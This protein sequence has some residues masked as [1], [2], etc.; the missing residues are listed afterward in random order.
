M[1]SKSRFL[2]RME[3]LSRSGGQRWRS[4]DGD[5]YYEW[6]P[7]HREIEVYDRRGYHLGA[8]DPDTG[9]VFKPAKPGRRIDV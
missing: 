2:D 7:F 5:R 9:V 3:R 6:D 1:A 8:A 4:P